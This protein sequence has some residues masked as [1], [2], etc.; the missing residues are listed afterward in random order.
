MLLIDNSA[1]TS[2]SQRN[3]AFA[4]ATVPSPKRNTASEKQGFGLLGGWGGEGRE[5]GEREGGAC[6]R[7]GTGLEQ[8]LDI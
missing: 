2:S 3:K 8:K 6:L 4:I 5:G 1:S 7:S